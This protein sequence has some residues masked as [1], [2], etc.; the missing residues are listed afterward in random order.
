M[1]LPL[2]KTEIR[3]KFDYLQ[4]ILLSQVQDVA[5]ETPLQV[6]TKLSKKTGHKLWIKREDLQPVH[7]FKVRGAYQKL[8]RLKQQLQP[9]DTTHVIT[10]S[11]GN[12]AQ[13][14]A[15]SAK[16]LSMKAVIYMPLTTPE[17][18][19]ESVQALGADVKLHGITFD[20]TCRHAMAL[21]AQSNIPFIPPF[22]DEDVIAGQGTVAR[23]LLNQ[24][25]ELDMV[26][27]PVGGGG[28]LAGMSLY[29]KALLPQVKVIGVEVDESACLQAALRAGHPVDLSHVGIFAD[30]VA[31]KRVGD[32]TFRLCQQ[33]CDDVITVNSDEVC[34]AIKDI[35]NDCRAIAE[36]SGALSLAGAKRYLAEHASNLASE[37]M[38]GSPLNIA[39]ILSGANLNFDSLRYVSERTALGEHREAIL[40]VT[41]D[42]RPGSFLGFCEAIGGRVI[43][44]FNYRMNAVTDSSTATIYVGLKLN[45]GLGDLDEI[46]ASLAE[47]QYQFIDLTRDETA[48]LHVR[49]MIGGVKRNSTHER[50]FSFEFPE[51]P[52]AL[53]NFLRQLGHRWNITLFHYRNHGAAR[54]DVLVGFEVEPEHLNQFTQFLEH[55]RDTKGFAWREETSNPGY[56]L[57]LG[58]VSSATQGETCT[59]L[60]E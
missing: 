56:Q 4:Q 52:G 58:D 45:G 30:G 48:K 35:F 36:P 53:L 14:V 12:H 19:V 15:L 32:E 57:F 25:S 59:S 28:L 29:I 44:E 51:Y 34:A 24:H 7:S 21:A 47:K 26:F 17:I 33:F 55:V 6:L 13:G 37:D 41:I 23:E 38:T 27:V 49:H 16:K 39:T 60:S 18:K 22:D 20:E 3:P 50:V 46:K 11:A 31:V 2:S 54:G 42:E 5:T 40:A 8:Y 43:T 10:A 9:G 1:N